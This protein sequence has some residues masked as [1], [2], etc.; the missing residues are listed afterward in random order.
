M[1][2]ELTLKINYDLNYSLIALRSELEDYQFAYFLNKSPF[3]LFQRLNKD[4]SYIIQE[5]KI[6]F[7]TF[8]H[9]LKSILNFLV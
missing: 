1:K 9:I 4:I 7:S 6:Y 2:N 5:K 3:F 8:Q